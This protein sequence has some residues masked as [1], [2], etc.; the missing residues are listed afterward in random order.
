MYCVREAIIIFWFSWWSS[1]LH[2]HLH[3]GSPSLPSLSSLL[4]LFS[5]QRHLLMEISTLHAIYY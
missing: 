3:L 2:L 5:L 4:F 1:H